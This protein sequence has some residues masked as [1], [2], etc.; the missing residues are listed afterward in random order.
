MGF[1]RYSGASRLEV[2][3]DED[4]YR[5]F[6]QALELGD[7]LLLSQLHVTGPGTLKS[8]LCSSFWST[9]TGLRVLVWSLSTCLGVNTQRSVDWC[10]HTGLPVL[11]GSVTLSCFSWLRLSR[12]NFVLSRVSSLH[13]VTGL[14]VLDNWVLGFTSIRWMSS[15]LLATSESKSHVQLSL[16]EIVGGGRG[17]HIHFLVYDLFRFHHNCFRDTISWECIVE[18]DCFR[19]CLI[20]LQS[21]FSTTSLGALSTF[22][23]MMQ[24]VVW[25]D[26]ALLD[27]GDSYAWDSRL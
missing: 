19:S 22:A 24:D 18:D 13:F 21:F 11:V 9:V 6:S 23:C 15:L 1:K 12:S 10:P 26:P 14:P 27:L 8:M 3:L 20:E 25:S 4:D 16:W 7:V 2:L 5:S 17:G